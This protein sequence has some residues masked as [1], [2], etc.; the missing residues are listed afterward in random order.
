[1]GAGA[2]RRVI[3]ASALTFCISLELHYPFIA[4]LFDSSVQLVP[5]MVGDLRSGAL[6]QCAAALSPFF[7]LPENFFVISSDFCHW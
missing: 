2:C 6:Q 3:S 4:E 5:I 7:A 1:M